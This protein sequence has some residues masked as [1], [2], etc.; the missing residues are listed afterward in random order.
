MNILFIAPIPPPIN[1][2]SKASKVLLDILIQKEY[3][4]TVVNLSKNS[5]KS[6]FDSI[7]RFFNIVLIL[8]KIWSNRIGK[9]VIYLSLAESFFGN[10]RDLLIYCI[11]YGSKTKIFLHMLGGAGMKNIL[12]SGGPI[13]LI[14]CFFLKKVSGVIVEG[15]VNF[16]L[17]SKILPKE[18]VHVVPNFAEDFL[19]AS[20]DVIKSKF[21]STK[22]FQILYLSN[23]I[24]GKGY[25]EL[26]DAYLKLD[27]D[28]QEQLNIVF[29]GGFESI[30]SKNKFLNKIK[31]HSGLSYLGNFIDGELKKKLYFD[32]HFFCLPTYYP[33]EGQPISILEA[34]ATGCVVIT[35]NHSGIP[36]IFSDKVNGFL[37]EKESVDSIKLIIHKIFENRSILKEIAFFNRNEALNKFRISIYQESLI[38]IFKYG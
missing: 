19:F 25:D 30:K 1:G 8:K 33:F 36:Y 28:Y 17:F 26:A 13:K 3:N 35:T 27:N 24:P 15:P 10:I 38:N 18:K 34:Y 7:G 2:Q 4:V 22:K 5:L 16:H 31:N 14:N 32:S 20:D 6:G 23:L 29:V 9:D 37:V 11:F 12:E 21:F